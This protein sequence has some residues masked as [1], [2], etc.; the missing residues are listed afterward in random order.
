VLGYAPYT[1]YQYPGGLALQ[2][3]APP[4]EPIP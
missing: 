2:L 4:P 1:S 3:I